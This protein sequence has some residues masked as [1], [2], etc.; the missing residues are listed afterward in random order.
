MVVG[1]KGRVVLPAELRQERGW[2]EGTVLVIVR[3]DRGVL[4]ESRDALLATIQ[5]GL[6]GSDLV[7]ELLRER[8]IEASLEDLP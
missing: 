8:R 7:G 4:I 5:S 3:T 1:N 6:A 2:D